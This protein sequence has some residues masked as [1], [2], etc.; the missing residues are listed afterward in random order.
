MI[1]TVSIVPQ[2]SKEIYD[3]DI[4]FLDVTSLDSPEPLLSDLANTAFIINILS[5][6]NALNEIVFRVKFVLTTDE[7]LL[8]P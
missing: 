2:I 5:V 1:Q 3:C 8:C 4:G 6:I 7:D